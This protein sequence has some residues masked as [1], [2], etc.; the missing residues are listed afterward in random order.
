[1]EYVLVTFPTNR[2]VTIDGEKSGTTNQ[3]LM[4]Q[5]GH[6]VL[7]M[8]GIRNY[9]PPEQEVLVSNTREDDPKTIEFKQI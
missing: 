3:T 9:T 1:M 2:F 6:H 5:R 4:V 7:S 8:M